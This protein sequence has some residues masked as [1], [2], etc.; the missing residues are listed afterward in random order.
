MPPFGFDNDR[1]GLLQMSFS[2][3]IDSRG[4]DGIGSEALKNLLQRFEEESVPIE[5][6]SALQD[7]FKK[8][9]QFGDKVRETNHHIVMGKA[10]DSSIRI[11]LTEVLDQ[12]ALLFEVEG[13][14]R[15]VVAALT[16]ASVKQALHY[17]QKL[18]SMVLEADTKKLAPFLHEF[19]EMEEEYPPIR[20]SLLSRALAFEFMA[21]KMDTLM[22]SSL[23]V[24][25]TPYLVVK[26]DVI[27]AQSCLLH[28]YSD[29]KVKIDYCSHKKLFS[30]AGSGVTGEAIVRIYVNPGKEVKI[31]KEGT[32][33]SDSGDC[34]RLTIAEVRA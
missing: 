3:E 6:S 32:V 13:D 17:F 26:S 28:K 16:A 20:V 19:S 22:L 29:C 31:P 25:A 30:S 7:L 10:V 12:V 24:K 9:G 11:E 21:G 33:W 23:K 14:K 27:S 8:A 15:R 18:E 4:D 2:E 1:L 5:L 34:D